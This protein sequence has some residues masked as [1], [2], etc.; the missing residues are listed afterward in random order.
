MIAN[1]ALS[2]LDIETSTTAI[3]AKSRDFFWYSR[4]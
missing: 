4:C 1:A 2:H 3:K